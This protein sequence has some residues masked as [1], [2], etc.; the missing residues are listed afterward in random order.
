LKRA[1]L[2]AIALLVFSQAAVRAQEREPLVMRIAFDWTVAGMVLGAGVG[3]ALW[4][5]DPAN[6][7]NALARQ[8]IEGGAL[9]AAFGM[10]FSFWIMQRNVQPP[11]GLADVYRPPPDLPMTQD[12]VAVL[13]GREDL[14]AS[15]AS[16]APMSFPLAQF[17]FR[18]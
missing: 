16:R 13:W 11:A 12:A 9:G 10:G 5:T 6:P 14:L 8:V 17:G 7:N 1:I 15:R 3:A 18:F 2:L 4:L